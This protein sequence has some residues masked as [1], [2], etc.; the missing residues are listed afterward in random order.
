MQY[1]ADNAIWIV[2]LAFAVALVGLAAYRKRTRKSG[3]AGKR[4][5]GPGSVK[6]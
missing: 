1:F 5:P 4:K 3:T 6:K 2:P